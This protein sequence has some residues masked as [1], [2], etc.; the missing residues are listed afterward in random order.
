MVKY[1]LKQMLYYMKLI[2]FL[3]LISLSYALECRVSNNI[4]YVKRDTY[5]AP[6]GCPNG[7]KCIGDE[8]LANITS[9]KSHTQGA[10]ESCYVTHGTDGDPPYVHNGPTQQGKCPDGYHCQDAD[11]LNLET[12]CKD[13]NCNSEAGTCLADGTESNSASTLT[14]SASIIIIGLYMLFNL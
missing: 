7:L 6:I 2:I 8:C 12:H 9:G 10:T 14:T 3:S 1:I 5:F 11:G 4:T 13:N